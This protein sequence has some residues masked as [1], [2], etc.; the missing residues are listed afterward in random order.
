[1]IFV[2]EKAENPSQIVD[3]GLVVILGWRY[4]RQNL[5]V[6][7]SRSERIWRLGVNKRNHA[8][9]VQLGREL[10]SQWWP[11]SRGSARGFV[12]ALLEF[13]HEPEHQMV[14]AGIL[15]AS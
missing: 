5:T 9:A 15:L 1:M 2:S 8:V 12:R 11:V 13:N 14:T 10:S 4:L 6:L 7:H 3:S